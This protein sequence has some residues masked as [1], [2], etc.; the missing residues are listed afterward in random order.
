[1][2]VGSNLYT[3]I[4]KETLCIEKAEPFQL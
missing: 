2:P 4:K 3:S 1:M